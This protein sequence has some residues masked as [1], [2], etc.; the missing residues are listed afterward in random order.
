MSLAQ[1]VE[2]AR[3]CASDS[4]AEGVAVDFALLR[5]AVS[6]LLDADEL[7]R[8]VSDNPMQARNEIRE[9]CRRVFA[10]PDWNGRSTALNESLVQALLDT[11]FGLGAIQ[12]LMDDEDI[13]E[14]MV[15]AGRKVFVERR[16]VLEPCAAQ[17]LDEK[18]VRALIDRI[19]SPLGRRVDE[20]SPMVDARLPSGHRVNVVIP[21]IAVDGPCMTIRKFTARV[22]TLDEMR[23]SG[24]FG[25]EEQTMLEWAVALRKNIA[26]CGGTGSGKT[27]MLNAL[28]C[29]IPQDE[30][31]VTIEDSAELRFLEHP[32][33]VRLEARPASSEG[34][35]AVTIRDLVRNA[36]RMRPDRIVVGEC[37]GYEALDMLQAMNTGHDGSLTTLHANSP[38]DMTMRLAAMVRFGSDLPVDVIEGIVASALDVVV[39]VARWRDGRRFV[40]SIADVLSADD[41]AGCRVVRA[42]ERVSPDAPGAWRAVPRWLD[43]AAHVDESLGGEVE[44]W[45]RRCSW[46]EP[47]LRRA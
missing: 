37:R 45:M 44:A 2:E 46:A 11:V 39:Q 27:T 26:V 23:G 42:Y 8:M 33:V 34:S 31:I 25:R 43:E 5:S 28:S 9:A 15:N 22:M 38:E 13:T 19:L 1:R 6:R 40:S 41:G 47:A 7:A 4:A 18:Q 30:R 14:V 21:P 10:R 12:P 35:G 32:H 20:S 36:L 24:S 17:H 16:G 29:L 3:S